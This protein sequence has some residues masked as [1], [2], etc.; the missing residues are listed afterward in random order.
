MFFSFYAPYV[1]ILK[2]LE[3]V[4][5][6]KTNVPHEKSPKTTPLRILLSCRGALGDVFLAS[7]L[8]PVLKQENASL[9]IEIGFLCDP[10][11]L[12]ALTTAQG[13]DFIHP[14]GK[15]TVSEL[16]KLQY[17]IS[18][19]L[20]PFFPNAIPYLKKAGI[21]Q[22]IGFD[23]RG[24]AMWLTDKVPFPS[25]EEYLPRMY[26]FLLEAI[27]LYVDPAR[28]TPSFPIHPSYP[29]PSSP[30]VVLHMGT[31]SPLKEW[32]LL[33]WRGV[34]LH[35]KEKGY[36]L[37]FTGKGRREKRQIQDAFSRIQGIDLCDQLSWQEFV[38]VLSKAQ[39]VVTV[40][41]AALHIAAAYEVPVVAL[42]LY[43]HGVEMW[44]PP[45]KDGYFLVG[46]RCIRTESKGRSGQ[47]IYLEDIEVEDVISCLPLLLEKNPS[48]L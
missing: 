22:R 30:Y 33:K 48:M 18:L 8:V 32:S 16:K 41:S 5:T 4:R 1:C 2:F 34:A 19:E 47:V 27:G 10:G 3:T 7:A 17:Q 28:I 26:R 25:Q 35:L 37:V 29:L 43:S 24:Y 12:P 21:P 44:I 9:K 20:H 36:T 23:G 31:S 45:V 11:A 15:N 38:F 13:I 40:D 46:K 14:L 6:R 39:L 42:Y